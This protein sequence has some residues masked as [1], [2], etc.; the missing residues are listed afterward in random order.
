MVVRVWHTGCQTGSLRAMPRVGASILLLLSALAAT[1][2]ADAGAL[3]SGSE[4]RDGSG[5]PE[6]STGAATD[7]SAA[8]GPSPWPVATAVLAGP[9]VHGAGH[10]VA[11]DT[12]TGL[13]LLQLEG[14]G[15]GA[16]VAGLGGLAVTGASPKLV[17]PLIGLTT[18]GAGVFVASALADVYGVLAPPG[19]FG[20]R[21]AQPALVLE[22]GYRHVV[23]RLFDYGPFAHLAAT[24]WLGQLR[25]RTRSWVAVGH[26]NQRLTGMANYRLLR[27]AG[28]S[29][30][31]VELGAIFHRYADE[32]FSMGFGELSLAGR[33][34]LS[35][36]GAR[37][38]GAFFDYALG[39]ALGGVRYHGLTTEADEMTL[40]RF[41]VGC[42]V[43]DG[44]SAQL[45]YDHRHDDFA[46]G[47]K[48]PGLGSG[49]IGHFGL[50]V[51]HYL[52][53][54][55]G[56]S[57]EAQTGSAHVLGVS[58]LHRRKRW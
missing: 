40:A 15:L 50:R 48:L 16:F 1:A 41:G 38:A 18:A 46:A 31:D 45:Y 8:T 4:R 33:V 51:E 13:R 3:H 43:G 19:G 25:L 29:F 14:L 7:T 20:T 5:E 54:D 22:G 57:A 21:V 49:A 55:W 52:S 44:G 6:A 9:V 42:F 53:P 32:Q 2:R 34:D 28:A 26:G 17:L 58:L 35:L 12:R 36:V 30:L 24:A 27:G 47:S 23:D 11:G 56:L 37:L 39:Y 10:L